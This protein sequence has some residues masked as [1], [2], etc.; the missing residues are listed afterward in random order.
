[1]CLYVCICGSKL[2]LD[3]EVSG[4]DRA[5]IFQTLISQKP[6]TFGPLDVQE[7]A[8]KSHSITYLVCLFIVFDQ[9]SQVFLQAFD[10]V[11]GT[12]VG[13]TKQRHDEQTHKRLEA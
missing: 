7:L 4:G 3:G 13:F 10:D 9:D 11:C 2:V 12:L 1:M 8:D 6:V 5:R